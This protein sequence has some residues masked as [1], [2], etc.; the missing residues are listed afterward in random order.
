MPSSVHDGSILRTRVEL[1]GI[2]YMALSIAR[3]PPFHLQLLILPTSGETNSIPTAAT[4]A[5][6]ISV[7]SWEVR[8]VEVGGG[9]G[10]RGGGGRGWRWEGVEVGGGGGESG[11]SHPPP[12]QP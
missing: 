12:V 6:G 10:E 5:M 2:P 4:Y 11:P 9:G 3:W 7:R 1:N 8:G